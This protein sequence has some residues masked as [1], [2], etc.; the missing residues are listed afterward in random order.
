MSVRVAGLDRDGLPEGVARLEEVVALR[1]HA[2]VASAEERVLVRREVVRRLGGRGPEVGLQHV[3]EEGRHDGADQLVLHVEE[4]LLR[5]VVALGPHRALRARVDELGRDAHLVARASH[6]PLEHVAHAQLLADGDDVHR[7]ALVA[8]R[9]IAGDHAQLRE[10]RQIGDQVLREPIAE[11][12][13]LLVVA[14]VREGQHRDAG[15]G[16]RGGRD[17][18]GLGRRRDDGGLRSARAGWGRELGDQIRHPRESVLAPRRER[19]RNRAGNLLGQLRPRAP[20][21]GRRLRQH[22]PD[23]GDRAVVPLPGV[24]PREQLEGHHAPGE[25]VGATVEVPPLHL[26]RRHVSHRSDHRAR[27]RERRDPG[28]RR[29]RRRIDGHVRASR[30]AEIQHLHDAVLA[31]HDVLGLDVAMHEPGRVRRLQRPR[32]VDEPRQL[33]RP[34]HRVVADVGA[35]RR[36]RD[37]LHRDVGHAV[38]LPQLEHRDLVGM[39][40]RSGG[41]RLADHARRGV[42]AGRFARELGCEQELQRDPP[43]ELG[44]EGPVDLPHP[45]LTEQALDRVVGERLSRGPHKSMISQARQAFIRSS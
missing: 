34:G 15:P 35:E 43:V 17:G 5:P 42:L 30:D 31:Q 21:R 24:P 11:V 29:R 40:Q 9:G 20:Q 23:Q 36:P 4:L 14:Q 26:L 39:V 27:A 45:P 12:L 2:Q 38:D 41:A 32:D 22:V 25:L 19:A 28:C 16:V 8:K 18:L 44:V 7:L 13:L 33:L 10:V 6:A 1:R 37:V 3:P